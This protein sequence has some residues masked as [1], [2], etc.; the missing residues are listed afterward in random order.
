VCQATSTWDAEDGRLHLSVGAQA[1][2]RPDEVRVSWRS[3][4]SGAVL[5]EREFE[6]VSANA[7]RGDCGC[8]LA[9]LRLDGE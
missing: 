3:A 4:G 9:A 7:P 6:D 1:L 5:I 2:G 8:Y